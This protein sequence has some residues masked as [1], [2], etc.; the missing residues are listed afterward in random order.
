MGGKR[1][2]S[3]WHGHTEASAAP[4]RLWPCPPKIHR[5]QA[6]YCVMPTEQPRC[7]SANH[8]G[9]AAVSRCKYSV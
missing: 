5:F 7:G 6:V 2:P 8:T 3:G 9:D 1:P 4:G